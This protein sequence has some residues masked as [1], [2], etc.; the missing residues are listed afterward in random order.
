MSLHT[1]LLLLNQVHLN[2]DDWVDFVESS[3]RKFVDFQTFDRLIREQLRR[4]TVRRMIYKMNQTSGEDDR[5]ATLD[6]ALKHLCTVERDP[7]PEAPCQA[8][9]DASSDPV[10]VGGETDRDHNF[11]GGGGGEGGRGGS[12]EAQPM[13]GQ[14][15]AGWKR[16]TVDFGGGLVL[17]IAV[18]AESSVADALVSA[19]V[20]HLLRALI[21]SRYNTPMHPRPVTP[22]HSHTYPGACRACMQ[23]SG[24]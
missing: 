14:A 1:T 20:S 16:I 17:T 2:F 5:D 18:E 4:F 13:G 9:V 3:Q 22:T 7:A 12:F 11:G 24:S 8:K 19:C 10:E 6:L 15:S 21:G 23:E